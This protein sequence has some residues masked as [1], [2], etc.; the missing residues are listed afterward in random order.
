MNHNTFDIFSWN[1][2]GING[3]KK[4]R[5]IFNWM[6]K[7]SSVNS[8]Y[9]LQETRSTLNDEKNWRKQWCGKLFFSH[10][11]S[12]SMGVLVGFREV[13]DYSVNK[14]VKDNNGRILILDVEIQGKPYLIINLYA[15]NDQAGQLVTLT[16]L[17]S[18][19]ESFE[20]NEERKIILGGN[21]NIIFDTHL[22]ADGGSPCL[23]V[24]TIQ[25]LMDIIS[26]YDLC[27]IFRV[28]NPDLCRFSWRQKTP[29]IQHR[30]D[31]I[32]IS[33]ELQEDVSEININPSIGSDHSILHLNISLNK[34][35]NS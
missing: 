22:D 34:H 24:G 12:N 15:D 2:R 8:I 10:G 21:F 26:E 7:H 11:T 29:L 18:L 19:L 3:Y 5:K 1:V 32:F 35:A 14:E 17:E 4:C 16:K 20:I 30:L 6:V 23:K 9:M 28:R 31:Y 25:K 27:D 33:S 13:L